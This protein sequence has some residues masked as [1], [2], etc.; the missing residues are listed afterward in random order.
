MNKDIIKLDLASELS[1]RYSFE[2]SNEIKVAIVDLLERNAFRPNIDHGGPYHLG[3][4]VEEGRLVFDIRNPDE[5]TLYK[6]VMALSSFRR[7][8]RDYHTI[9]NSY[10]E[11]I[12]YASPSQIEA[13][14]MG[15]RGLHDEGARLLQDRMSGK[16][17]TDWDTARRLF[18]LICALH[19]KG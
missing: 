14:D 10:Y 18:T 11:A 15:R 2:R 6:F 1:L 19:L 9:C 7:T 12:R 5:L 17:A 4:A 8:V 3:L 16:I 13:I